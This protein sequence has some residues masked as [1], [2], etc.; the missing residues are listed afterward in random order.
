M[1]EHDVNAYRIDPRR[2]PAWLRP[3]LA[4]AI[5]GLSERTLRRWGSMR[6]IRM[7]KPAC[8]AVLI[9]RD[10]VIAYLERSAQGAA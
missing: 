4:A 3:P 1:P 2:A 9:D 6:L 8:G 7:A 5:F 10:S